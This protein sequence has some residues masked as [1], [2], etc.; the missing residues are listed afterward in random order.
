MKDGS[1]VAIELQMKATI[2]SRIRIFLFKAVVQAALL[3]VVLVE[4]FGWRRVF[5]LGGGNVFVISTF[6][7]GCGNCQTA[8]RLQVL[9]RKNREVIYA[10][11]QLP[12][13]VNTGVN[14]LL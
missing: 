5:L 2:K 7:D 9:R 3:L 12:K 10:F 8:C 4:A 1:L 13:L 6:F 14:I 11:P